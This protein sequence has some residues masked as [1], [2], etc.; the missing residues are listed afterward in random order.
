MTTFIKNIILFSISVIL[1]IE[2]V[3]Y[4]LLCSK[5]Y[6][7]FY[8]GNEIYY[9]IEKSKKK[10][11]SKILLLGDSVANQLFPNNKY[12]YGINSL[13]CNQAIGLIGQ[14]LLLSN[15]LKVENEIDKVIILFHP[16]S[17][18]MNINSKY[19]YHYFLKPFNNKEYSKYF[20]E[21]VNE[22]VKKIPF[23]KFVQ[24]PH[25]KVTTWA[26]EFNSKDERQYTFLSPISIE[27]LSKIKSLSIQYDFE[28]EILPTPISIK[29][30]TFLDNIDLNEVTS[31]YLENEFNN[32]FTDI[33]FLEDKEFSDGVHLIKP[34][35]YRN[36]FEGKI[37]Q[38]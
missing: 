33:L 23:N 35:K 13:A 1:F 5:Q 10:N 38:Q 4:I 3:S 32:Y 16:T 34:G 28:L 25:I 8:P 31:N 11:K 15:Y 36:I 21:T 37:L 19:S 20:S 18:L 6:L 2:L 9:S 26:P 12:D 30:K 27:Y 22:Q 17:F 24:L 7:L 29:E 14:F